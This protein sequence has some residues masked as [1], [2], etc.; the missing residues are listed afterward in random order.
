[1]I[2]T[3]ILN[4]LA[5]GALFVSVASGLAL[6]YG[7]RGVVNFAHGALYMAG[8]Y[9]GLAVSAETGFFV[10]LVVVGVVF[11][12]A[13]FALDA[14]AF[15]RLVDRGPLTVLLLTFGLA[16]VVEE[17]ARAI[18]GN[19][20]RALATPDV[21]DG[22][23]SVLGR[24]FPIYRLFVILVVMALAVAVFLLLR[25]TRI[26]LMIRAG[27]LSPL[28]A[29][30]SGIHIDRVS[31][32]VVAVGS[33]LAGMAG[34]LAG[35]YLSISPDMGTD[36]LVASFIV[37]VVGGLGSFGGAIV[38]ALALGQLQIFGTAYLPDVAALVPYAAMAGVLLWKPLGL[39]GTRV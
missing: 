31:G 15:R 28:T 18:W 7:L 30:T 25:R 11:A 36:I 5:L 9:V 32:V 6:I 16:L 27:S 1:M 19:R 33:A 14:L 20:H 29:A 24:A 38:A 26:G 34:L 21:L 10:A 8:A 39:A 22:T 12:A 37:V 4:G 2:L 35:P 13:G 23:I 3:H 17:V